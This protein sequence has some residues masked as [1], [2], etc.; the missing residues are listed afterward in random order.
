MKKDILPDSRM[1]V[2]VGAIP[3]NILGNFWIPIYCAN[4]GTEGGKVP[5]ENMT[6]AFWLCNSCYEKQGPVAGT[7]AVR[8]EVFW[9]EVNNNKKGIKQEG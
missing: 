7:M 2:P 4:C 6:F 8:D 5:E 1:R 9:E 3:N